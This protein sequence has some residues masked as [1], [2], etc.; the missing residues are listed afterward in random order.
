[1]ASSAVTY[2]ANPSTPDACRTAYFI[3]ED[4]NS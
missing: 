1:M 2:L 3:T 4:P